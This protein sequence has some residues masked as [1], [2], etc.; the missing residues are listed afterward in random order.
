[1][2]DHNLY[3]KKDNVICVCKYKD[4]CNYDRQK[5]QQ[6]FPAIFCSY[7][8][9]FEA[10]DKLTD[11]P[12]QVCGDRVKAQKDGDIVTCDS[13]KCNDTVLRR[14]ENVSILR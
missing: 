8:A 5:V 14:L 6:V 12:C 1:M 3:L 7:F 11:E 9:N 10:N 13:P 4:R 2:A